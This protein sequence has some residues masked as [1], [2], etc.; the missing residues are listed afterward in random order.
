MPRA[1]IPVPYRLKEYHASRP[2]PGLVFL[3][4][5]NYIRNA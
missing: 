4:D 2:I 3:F 1:K 5:F